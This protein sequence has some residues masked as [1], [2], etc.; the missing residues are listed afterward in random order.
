[1]KIH[2]CF[3]FLKGFLV[4]PIIMFSVGG[5]VYTFFVHPGLARLILVVIIIVFFFVLSCVCGLG[6]LKSSRLKR[7]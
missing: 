5:F 6:S 7:M 1:M 3:A 4:V 2:D